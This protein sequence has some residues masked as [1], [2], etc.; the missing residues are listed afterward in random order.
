MS[1]RDQTGEGGGVILRNKRRE[2]KKEKSAGQISA[3]K[4]GVFGNTAVRKLN[5]AL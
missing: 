2:V 4:S 3:K 1:F 5:Q